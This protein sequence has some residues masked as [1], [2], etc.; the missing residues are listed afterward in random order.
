[1]LHLYDFKEWTM[2]QVS[3]QLGVDESRLSQIRAAALARLRM[4]LAP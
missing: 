2:K 3:I 4:Q 1:V